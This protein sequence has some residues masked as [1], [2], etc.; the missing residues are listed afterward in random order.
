LISLN[1]SVFGVILK[2]LEPNLSNK[3][4]DQLIWTVFFFFLEQLKFEKLA[5]SRDSSKDLIF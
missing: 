3:V 1:E 4:K 5:F 2:N